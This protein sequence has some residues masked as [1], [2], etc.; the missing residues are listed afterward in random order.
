MVGKQRELA[1][2]E[3]LR[4]N[5]DGMIP[6]W[7]ESTSLGTSTEDR[8]G[9]DIVVYTD[10]GKLFLQIKG[11]EIQVQKFLAKHRKGNIVPFIVEQTSNI[12]VL[13]EK[14]IACLQ[15]ERARILK[16]RSHT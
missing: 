15:Q 10:I 1:A 6:E 14:L 13:R 5:E 7:I 2:L 8:A 11:T 9:I 4:F 3:A 12:Q 16:L